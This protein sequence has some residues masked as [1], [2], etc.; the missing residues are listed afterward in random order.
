MLHT[1]SM[2]YVEY[3]EVDL[4]IRNNSL[5]SMVWREGIIA[6]EHTSHSSNVK[7]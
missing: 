6:Y 5:V 4:L 3:N 2:F 7:T 1:I